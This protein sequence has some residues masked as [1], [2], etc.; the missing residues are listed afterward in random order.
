MRQLNESI[1]VDSITDLL[2]CAFDSLGKSCHNNA[3]RDR[4]RETMR[5]AR[6]GLWCCLLLLLAGIGTVVTAAISDEGKRAIEQLRQRHQSAEAEPARPKMRDLAEQLR[7]KLENTENPE[8]PDKTQ[9]TQTPVVAPVKPSEQARPNAELE[10]PVVATEEQTVAAPAATD[11]PTYGTC[12]DGDLPAEKYDL[13][14]H[15]AAPGNKPQAAA[16]Y[17]QKQAASSDGE[18]FPGFFA[19]VIAVITLFTFGSAFAGSGVRGSPPGA[20]QAAGTLMLL[21]AIVVG[22]ITVIKF[23]PILLLLFFGYVFS[24]SSRSSSDSG[25][26]G[27]G[28]GLIILL[29][30][31]GIL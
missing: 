4:G 6:S 13:V 28:C 10:L 23:W 18:S 15:P 7:K 2:R 5:P 31:L 26:C 25:C 30:L 21:G 1:K 17:Q 8:N 16:T 19:A 24:Q 27:C 12:G 11:T 14:P 9:P 20:L 22:G 3:E 29:L